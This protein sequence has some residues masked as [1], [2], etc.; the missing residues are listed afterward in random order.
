[1]KEEENLAAVSW[2]EGGRCEE[3]CCEGC[4]GEKVAGCKEALKIC[5]RWR[6]EMPTKLGGDFLLHLLETLK[7]RGE[8][9]LEYKL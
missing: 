9:S 8:S 2:R 1:M 4:C 3:R 6:R 5:V 7:T